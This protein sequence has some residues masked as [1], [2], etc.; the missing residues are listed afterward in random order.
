M[1]I[2][3]FYEFIT[4]TPNI[5]FINFNLCDKD[6]ASSFTCCTQQEVIN[7]LCSD[8]TINLNRLYRQEYLV[9]ILKIIVI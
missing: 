1:D 9:V 3:T 5:K 6:G 8:N 7:L 4:N 2:F